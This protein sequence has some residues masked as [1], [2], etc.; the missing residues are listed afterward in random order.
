MSNQYLHIL[1]Q[2]ASS[3]GWVAKDNYTWQEKG[4][5]VSGMIARPSDSA[6]TRWK[7]TKEVAYKLSKE[8]ATGRNP[9][10]AIGTQIL[11]PTSTKTAAFLGSIYANRLRIQMK[12]KRLKKIAN[13]FYQ[14]GDS[15]KGVFAWSTKS[16]KIKKAGD[17]VVE[18]FTKELSNLGYKILPKDQTQIGSTERK[19]Y[20]TLKMMAES[21]KE[22]EINQSK[23]M[24]NKANTNP[25][26][27]LNPIEAKRMVDK[28]GVKKIYTEEFPKALVERMDTAGVDTPYCLREPKKCAY[29]AIG[30]AVLLAVTSAAVTYILK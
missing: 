8:K 19:I 9:K 27:L 6:P 26:A 18:R 11:P 20:T 24:A 16:S 30:G 29:I 5:I 3:F 7:H 15:K 23:E 14:D 2:P 22:D 17:N 4:K 25:L 13:E 21:F 12:D 1:L 10:T 28:Y